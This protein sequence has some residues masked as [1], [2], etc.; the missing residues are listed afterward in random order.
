MFILP[1]VAQGQGTRGT[2]RKLTLGVK[3]IRGVQLRG[4]TCMAL[5]VAMRTWPL[6]LEGYI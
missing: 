2:F 6:V 3:D 5:F 4:H 1:R